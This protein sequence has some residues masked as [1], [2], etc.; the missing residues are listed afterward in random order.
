MSDRRLIFYLYFYSDPCSFHQCKSYQDCV[1]VDN[2]AKCQ[3]PRCT[4]LDDPVCANNNK[5][6]PN[7]CIMRVKACKSTPGLTMVK[8]GNCGKTVCE[9]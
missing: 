6:Y 4:Q 9:L 3:C 5:S 8:K 1:V 7:E 2:K